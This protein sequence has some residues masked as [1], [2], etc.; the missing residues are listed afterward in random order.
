MV[1]ALIPAW[2]CSLK[3]CAPV[4]C[5]LKMYSVIIRSPCRCISLLVY[6]DHVYGLDLFVFCM[7]YDFQ[8]DKFLNFLKRDH[9]SVYTDYM[10]VIVNRLAGWITLHALIVSADFCVCSCAQGL[11]RNCRNCASR[12]HGILRPEAPKRTVESYR[13]STRT[14]GKSRFVWCTPL[15]KHVSFRC[16]IGDI[17]AVS[18]TVANR[19]VWS[20]H[21]NLTRES[22]SLH[23]LSR[24]PHI[25]LAFE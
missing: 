22:T 13:N 19:W 5:P 1:L 24:C 23:L 8:L 25:H 10:L 16:A 4:H 11:P 20:H 12:A 18:W 21:L 6:A 14:R 15:T 9:H 17:A 3:F 7:P 2:P